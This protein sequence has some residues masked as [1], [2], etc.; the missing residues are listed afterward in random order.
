M[1]IQFYK[2]PK[3]IE[4]QDKTRSF[5]TKTYQDQDDIY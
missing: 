3:N 1:E 4:N 2:I 5:V